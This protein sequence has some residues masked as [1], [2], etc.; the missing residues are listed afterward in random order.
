MPL[1]EY[2]CSHCG[3]FSAFAAMADSQRD[4]ICDRCGAAAQRRLSAAA[5]RGTPRSLSRAL[6]RSEASAHQPRVKSAC[7]DGCR[8]DH[9]S[10]RAHT[11]AAGVDRPWMIGH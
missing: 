5:L 10:G 9:R 3:G 4:A 8:H 7:S 11:H 2:E 1:Y 6:D